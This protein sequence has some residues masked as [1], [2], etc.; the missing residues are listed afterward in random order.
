MFSVAG[1]IFFAVENLSLM[2]P[3]IL[4][5]SFRVV[6]LALKEFWEEICGSE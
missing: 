3:V 2:S 4:N 6:L 1:T 5:F